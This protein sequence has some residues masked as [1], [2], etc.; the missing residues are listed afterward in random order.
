[1]SCSTFGI[2]RDH[3]GT[4]LVECDQCDERHYFKSLYFAKQWSNK[5]SSN[6]ADGD[7]FSAKYA[8]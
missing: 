1:M 7:R 2:F 4:V 8:I 5:H 6:H 3:T